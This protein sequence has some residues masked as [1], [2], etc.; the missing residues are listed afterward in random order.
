MLLRQPSSGLLA[1]SLT[2]FGPGQCR[3]E[4]GGSYSPVSQLLQIDT[5]GCMEVVRERKTQPPALF[6]PGSQN[7]Q[8][9]THTG[10]KK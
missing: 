8:Q 7:T 4:Q 3:V 1:I 10:N 5:A 6:Q 2:I 9:V